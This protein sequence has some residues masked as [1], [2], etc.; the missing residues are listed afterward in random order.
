MRLLDF[1]INLHDALERYHNMSC[2]SQ[3]W[4]G[5]KRCWDYSARMN[6]LKKDD[7]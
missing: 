1:L 5:F 3:N 2:A 4:A 7:D 6:G